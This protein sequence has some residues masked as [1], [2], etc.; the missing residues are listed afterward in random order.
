MEA[1]GEALHVLLA[2]VPGVGVEPTR[3]EARGILSWQNYF[4]QGR[5]FV[6]F[7]CA[8]RVLVPTALLRFCVYLRGGVGKSVGKTVFTTR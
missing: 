3:A 8:T 1:A 7:R 2:K 6:A 5:Y 4:P